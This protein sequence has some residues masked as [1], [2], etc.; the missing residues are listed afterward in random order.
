MLRNR[1]QASGLS[2]AVRHYNALLL[3]LFDSADVVYYLL[4]GT[5]F[6]GLAI[7]R[8]DDLRLRG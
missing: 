1:P 3:G 7:R 5:V 2:V 8:L 6:L 4:F